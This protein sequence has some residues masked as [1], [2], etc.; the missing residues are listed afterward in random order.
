MSSADTAESDRDR[1]R[2][3]SLLRRAY[4]SVSPAGIL[5]T[6]GLAMAFSISRT[7]NGSLVA[8]RDGTFGGWLLDTGSDFAGHALMVLVMIALIAPVMSLGPAS[9]W[10]R[11]LALLLALLVAAPICALIRIAQLE[12]GA[13]ALSW[14]QMVSRFGVRFSVRYGYMAALVVTVVE[15]YRYEVRSIAAM[16]GAEVDRLALDRE[17]AAAR[18]QVLQAQ[19]EPHFLFN[20]LANVRRLFQTDAAV[21]RRMLANLMRYLEVALPRMREDSS[22]L[23]REATLIEAFLSVQKIRMG[24]RLSFEIDIPAE[25]RQLAVPPMML[26]TL[27]ENALKHGLNPLPEGGLVRI[28]ARVDGD[29]LVVAVSDTGRGFGEGTSGGG[30]G[31]ANIRARLAAM[32]GADASLG[33]TTHTRRAS[34]GRWTLTPAA[35]S[36]SCRPAPWRW[37]WAASGAGRRSMTSRSPSPPTSRAVASIPPRADRATCW[38]C[39]SS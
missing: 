20:T 23:E 10:R 29:R 6:L 2:A 5:A 11:A 27:V 37:P 34:P 35:T 1:R 4:A 33:L 39:S 14:A 18:L 13:E 3:N 30:T 7:I 25:L 12:L 32:F 24:R 21:G 36:S 31:L 9:G 17:M 16:H 8:V 22:T 15:F 28:D 19:I 26:L 38:R